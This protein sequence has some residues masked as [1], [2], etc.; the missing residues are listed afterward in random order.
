MAQ[1]AIKG[2]PTRGRE[3]IQL[4]VM[5]G[6]V[7]KHQI[8]AIRETYV[9]FVDIDGIIRLLQIDQLLPEQYIVYSLEEFEEKFP[10]KVGDKVEVRENGKVLSISNMIWEDE[11]STV[12]YGDMEDIVYYTAD[13]LKP[14]KEELTM[15]KKSKLINI[16]PKLVGNECVHFPIP[17]GMK[18]EVKDGMCYLYRD[19]GEHKE[20]KCL[21]ELK[22]YLDNA[23]PEQLEEDWKELEKFSAV[24]PV[25][26]EYVEQCKREGVNLQE[27]ERKL[28]EALEK[29]TA[30]SLNK[31][32]DEENMN[33]NNLCTR[34]VYAVDNHCGL[35]GFTN[36]FNRPYCSARNTDKL[37]N[38]FELQPDGYFSWVDSKPQYPKDYVEC[39]KVLG[40]SRDDVD[41]DLPHPYQQKM[42]NLFKLHICRDAYW[43]ISGEEL[44]LD[45]PWEPDWTNTNS[46]KYCIYYV[47]N[48]I[49]K[50]PM[51][52]VRH[53]LAFPTA[54]M[55]DAFYDNFKEL[56]EQC[57]ELL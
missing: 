25:A 26:D 6:G 10:Y 47:G 11:L 30:E 27:L 56:I 35:R 48:E 14:Y 41:I 34:C 16:Q 31:W 9:Y 38:G 8:D 57:K 22:E 3:V 1:L 37:P 28:D 20:S 52:E 21:Q 44:G 54:E 45:K 19:C 42:F 32:L 55:R 33:T 43:K 51:L 36:D 23:T 7:N 17:T 53:F 4:L 5:L 29:E 49:K 12:Y 24:G 40:I 2:H 46:N 39:C 18:L 13:E 50:Q 15:K